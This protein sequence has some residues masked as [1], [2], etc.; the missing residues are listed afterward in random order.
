MPA[1]RAALLAIAAVIKSGQSFRI[2]LLAHNPVKNIARRILP[3]SRELKEKSIEDLNTFLSH[4]SRHFG[5]YTH[6]TRLL[7]SATGGGDGECPPTPPPSKA[8]L[9]LD[10]FYQSN[11]LFRIVV[12]GN[13]AILET[14]SKLGPKSSS[15]VSPKT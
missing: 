8:E 4:N 13:G 1:M 6:R 5:P 3:L 11:L 12:V 9:I 14:T 15:S 7:S 10:E 2:V